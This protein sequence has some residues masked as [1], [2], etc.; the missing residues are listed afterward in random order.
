MNNDKLQNYFHK[1]QKC[2]PESLYHRNRF[3]L[4]QTA[5][6]HVLRSNC[7]A[8]AAPRHSSSAAAAAATSASSS[9]EVAAPAA[10]SFPSLGAGAGTGCRVGW[11]MGRGV[12]VGISGDVGRCMPMASSTA[13]YASSFASA[14][15]VGGFVLQLR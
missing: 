5:R 12:V 9:E 2:R 14:L 6:I 10:A 8:A 4:E 3:R 1:Q 11:G 7:T 13:E 15:Y